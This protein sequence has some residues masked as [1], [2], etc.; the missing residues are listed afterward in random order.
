MSFCS[1]HSAATN[2]RKHKILFELKSVT[3]F[4][5]DLRGE[6]GDTMIVFYQGVQ[7]GCGCDFEKRSCYKIQNIK[8]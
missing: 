6:G 5:S 2:T 8:H 3:I 7:H 1:I 4:F